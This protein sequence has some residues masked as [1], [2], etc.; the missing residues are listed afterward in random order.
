[1]KKRNVLVLLL[2]VFILAMGIFLTSCDDE[3]EAGAGDDPHHNPFIGTWNSSNGWVMVFS[4]FPYTY[5]ITSAGGSKESGTYEWN[6]LNPNAATMKGTAG[7]FN[8][9]IQNNSLTYG[10][11]VYV[12]Q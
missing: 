5:S 10:S 4:A 2:I 6:F 3:N 7:T 9:T 8:V 12:K 1:M 11:N